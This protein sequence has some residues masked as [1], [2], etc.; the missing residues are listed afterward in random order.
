[1]YTT[2]DFMIP[3]FYFPL[4][5][6]QSVMPN[7]FGKCRIVWSRPILFSCWYEK[8]TSTFFFETL[9]TFNFTFTYIHP[10]IFQQLSQNFLGI[11]HLQKISTISNPQHLR[12]DPHLMAPTLLRWKVERIRTW[13]VVDHQVSRNPG[14]PPRKDGPMIDLRPKDFPFCPGDFFRFNRRVSFQFGKRNL[15]IR[16]VQNILKSSLICMAD[17]H[18][19]ATNFWAG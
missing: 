4:L 5:S 1:M 16:N 3:F 15:Y 7:R 17:G 12:S 10:T 9:N 13:R 18:R 6:A 8:R 19:L 11:F 2:T 14:T